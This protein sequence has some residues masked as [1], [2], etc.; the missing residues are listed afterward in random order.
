[1]RDNQI[2]SRPEQIQ[3]GLLPPP[4]NNYITAHPVGHVEFHDHERGIM[5]NAVNAAGAM[6]TQ[7]QTTHLSSKVKI[8]R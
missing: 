8:R 6:M 2:V 7:R 4:S 5:A 3:R 1:M